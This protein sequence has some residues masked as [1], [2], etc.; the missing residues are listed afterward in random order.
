MSY[1]D[2]ENPYEPGSPDDKLYQE[3]K[4]RAALIAPT[5]VLP[6]WAHM[7][8]PR[9]Q[10]EQGN[11]GWNIPGAITGLY[12]AAGTYGPQ[13]GN[14]AAR[15]AGFKTNLPSLP[16]TEAAGKMADDSARWALNTI[17]N[18]EAKDE[19]EQQLANL[20]FA[21]ASMAIPGGGALAGLPRVAR[22]IAHAVM[23]TGISGGIAGTALAGGLMSY[24]EKKQDDLLRELGFDP[25]AERLADARAA[26]SGAVDLSQPD[27]SH[28]VA[29]PQTGAAATVPFPISLVGQANAAQPTKTTS[30]STTSAEGKYDTLAEY[31][32]PDIKI[33]TPDF[34]STGETG[35]TMG[36]GLGVG[37]IAAVAAPLVMRYGGRVFNPAIKVITGRGD[38]I[39][40]AANVAKFNANQQAVD[41][42]TVYNAPAGK[43]EGAVRGEAP[44]PDADYGWG[45]KRNAGSPMSGFAQKYYDQNRV[46]TEYSNATAPTT[47][48]AREMEAKIG[49]VNN[50]TPMMHQINEQMSTGVNKANGGRQLPSMK[51]ILQDLDNAGEAK[52]A[53][54]DKGMWSAAELNR[55]KM[56]FDTAVKDGT[57]L[58]DDKAFR[59]N[60]RN[61]DS[62]ALRADRAAMMN[63]PVLAD[64]AQRAWLLQA[65]HAH[66]LADMGRITPTS[67]RNMVRDQPHHV[68]SVDLEGNVVDPLSFRDDKTMGWET[69]PTKAIDALIQYYS[70]VHVEARTNQVHDD[71]IRNGVLYQNANPNAA[72]VITE[73]LDR[74]GNPVEGVKG[75]RT[76]TTYRDGVAHTW[77]IDNT[78]LYN[79]LKGNTA[80]T[81]MFLNTA[82]SLRRSLQSGTTGVAATIIGQRPFSVINL[83]RNI[84]QIASDRAPGTTFGMLDRTMQRMTGGKVGY[85]GPD[86]THWV[87]SYNE[88][89]RGSGAIT[90]RYMADALRRKGNPVTDALRSM[91]GDAWV[92]SWADTLERNWAT[93]NA[94][95]RKAEG[96]TGGGSGGVYE[97]PL[98]N[99]TRGNNVAYNPMA[100]VTPRLFHPDGIAVPFTRIRI[101]G[102][103]GSVG[104]YINVRNWMREIH[105]EIGDGANAYYWK[106]M[107]DNP[108]IS[109]TQR[110]FNTRQV[111]GDPSNRGAG[112]LAQKAAH[113]VPWINPSIQDAVRMGRNLRD[114]PISFVLGT[115]HTLGMMA[116]SSILSAML[117]GNRHLNMLGKLMSTHNRAS[118]MTF[119]HNPENEHDYTQFSLPQRWRALYPIILQAVSD[120][121]G[122]FN[123]RQGEDA[124]NRVVHSLA[125]MYNH[126]I[127][128]STAKSSVEGFKDFVGV[129]SVPMANIAAG[130][131]GKRINEPISQMLDNVVNGKP[132]TDNILSNAA[133]ANR[134]PG[135]AAG[136]SYISNDDA[137]WVHQVLK[138]IYGIAG[139]GMYNH[140]TNAWQ[141]QSV[142]HD[143]A[144]TFGSMVSDAGQTWRD[145]A[146]FG[147]M[148]WGN[149][150]RMDKRNPLAEAN[151]ATW[152]TMTNPAFPKARDVQL[153]GLTRPGGVAVGIPETPKVNNDPRMIQ[154]FTTVNNFRGTIG[155]TIQPQ[156]ADIEAQY[157]ELEQ[158]PHYAPQMKRSM[159]ND[160]RAKANELEHKK[161]LMLENMHARLSQLAGGKHVDVNTINWQKGLEQF[162]D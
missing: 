32:R 100:D 82:D 14:W 44:L 50:S 2:P 125:D 129:A 122:A 110:V 74:H 59:V 142:T 63:D 42:G 78:D 33:M 111:L 75:G 8:V 161:G 107:R 155:K 144:D 36:E 95:A 58:H 128:H 90:Q 156:L 7:I 26:Q 133:G 1:L 106:G 71:I 119:F 23:P 51:G 3:G 48:V 41:L 93:S 160:M 159:L 120:G 109:E 132:L 20:A 97:R 80:K 138:S 87:G 54:W 99:T 19:Q 113:V 73:V 40:T 55:R 10:D 94:A 150:V 21:G 86:P 135:Q 76:I 103:R 45:Q 98:Y 130:V 12:N 104:A 127:T 85:R 65:K 43:Y 13:A 31:G 49:T 152:R 92:N 149:N 116:T 70:K 136:S 56:N 29:H 146:P 16:G 47:G 139:D 88:A 57:P 140:L 121:I 5:R 38:E 17:P 89:I 118:N 60:Y 64:I 114:N 101:P 68:P 37:M 147:N 52:Q 77:N 117:G 158:D 66:H 18:V 81:S 15:Q 162:H 79:A 148:V 91:K 96:A 11:T 4:L 105:Q 46:L 35:M 134:L 24:E 6:A 124:Y 39:N 102:T 53:V 83:N 137:G 62:A 84:P 126:L 22:G 72:R 28:D 69:P 61:V 115:V 157:R 143:I 154:M 67:A 141:R 34:G 9:G 153:E 108:N 123:M 131:M 25:A 145:N 30:P 27:T 112:T 151:D